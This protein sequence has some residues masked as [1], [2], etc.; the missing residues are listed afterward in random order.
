MSRV[1]LLVVD[2]KIAD[3]VDRTSIQAKT[4]ARSILRSAGEYVV[5]LS[6]LRQ[7]LTVL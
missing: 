4:L 7:M 5:H 2:G 3:G 6:A 1:S